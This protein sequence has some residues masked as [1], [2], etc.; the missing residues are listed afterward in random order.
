MEKKHILGQLVEEKSAVWV[1]LLNSFNEK[2][3]MDPK[4]DK[5]ACDGQ[6]TTTDGAIISSLSHID[7][8]L[9]GDEAIKCIWHMTNE[10]FEPKECDISDVAR[11]ICQASCGD[12]SLRESDLTVN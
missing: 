6:L 12:T 5:T 8:E 9:K 3:A 11:A 7:V 2:C 1:N 10:K 4:T